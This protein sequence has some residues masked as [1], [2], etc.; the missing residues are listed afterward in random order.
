MSKRFG[1]HDQLTLNWRTTSGES[2]EAS[3]QLVNLS[4]GGIAVRLDTNLAV[5]QW[6]EIS[7]MDGKADAQ[8]RYCQP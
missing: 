7:G 3:A 2:V 6:V 4:E 1:L 8:V 5:G